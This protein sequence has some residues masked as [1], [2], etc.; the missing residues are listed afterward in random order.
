MLPLSL[1][2]CSEVTMRLVPVP[3]FTQI[4]D[5]RIRLGPVS[6]PISRVRTSFSRL[7]LR[8]SRRPSDQVMVSRHPQ[9]LVL[10]CAGPGVRGYLID[11]EG[12][13]APS[14][15]LDEL[16]ARLLPTGAS[17]RITG[18]YR[19]EED[20][21]VESE[22]LYWRSGRRVLSTERRELLGR[23]GSRRLISARS[24]PAPGG[25]RSDHERRL[26]AV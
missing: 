7:G 2:S 17:C 3:A 19:E 13:E 24:A 26:I 23:N 21:I 18:H 16:M 15:D 25:A 8:M 14:S 4:P 1:E 10:S 9:G 12:L 5:G 20:R 6:G 11:G 22:A